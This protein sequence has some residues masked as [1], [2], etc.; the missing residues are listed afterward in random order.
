MGNSWPGA[1]EEPGQ[2]APHGEGDFKAALEILRAKRGTQWTKDMEA[3]VE[4]HLRSNWPGPR[5]KE[6]QHQ[7]AE[8]LCVTYDDQEPA[9]QRW[10]CRGLPTAETQGKE[11]NSQAQDC[12]EEPPRGTGERKSDP[13]HAQPRNPH[14]EQW[15]GP[16]VV[17]R[18]LELGMG[19]RGRGTRPR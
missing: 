4:Y 7:W 5:Y 6:T 3:L 15:A 17:P 12:R 8:R 14:E 11:K 18:R 13:D 1:R 9:M 19:R 16:R 10:L 2:W